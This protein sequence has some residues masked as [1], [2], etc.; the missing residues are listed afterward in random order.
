M[1][2]KKLLIALTAVFTAY[3]TF[4]Q[5]RPVALDINVVP[6]ENSKIKI[7]WKIPENSEPAITG[8][9]ICRDTKQI[10]SYEQ[11]SSLGVIAQLASDITEYTDF[12]E[13][14]REYFYCVI[15]NTDNGPYM[16][17]LPSINTSVGG[18]RARKN[19]NVEN[20]VITPSETASSKKTSKPVDVSERMR[21]IPLPTPGLVD[22]NKNQAVKLGSKAMNASKT[23]GKNYVGKKNKITKMH[24]FEEDLVCPE[25]GDDYF[26]FKILKATFAKKDFKASIKELNDFLSV[27][28]SE[29]TSKRATFYLAQS[30]YFSKDYQN[31]LFNFLTVSEEYPKLSKKWID[32]SLDMIEIN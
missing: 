14:F 16:I 12:V 23:L 7:T 6:K 19:M 24:I 10:T 9:L 13:D 30:Y 25:G 3:F 11:L 26:L 21:D 22:T 17:L 20:E 27:R 29:S 4:A 28:H 18:I 32:S 31:A 15:A 1:K 5:S 8:F 2:L